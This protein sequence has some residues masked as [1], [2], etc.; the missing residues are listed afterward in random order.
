MT[1]TLLFINSI[2]LLICYLNYIKKS[3]ERYLKKY[4][5]KG[6]VFG[7]GHEGS[8]CENLFFNIYLSVNYYFY[9]LMEKN[10]NVKYCLLFINRFSV[11]Y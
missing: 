10:E 5:V 9:S 2:V 4:V 7:R 6:V 1:T 11:M 8:L 3:Q